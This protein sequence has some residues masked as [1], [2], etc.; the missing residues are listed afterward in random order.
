[1]YFTEVHERQSNYFGEIMAIILSP[2][3]EGGVAGAP[4]NQCIAKQIPAGV[5][6]CLL[7][8]LPSR[9]LDFKMFHNAASSEVDLFLR[10][11]L[12]T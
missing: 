2:P 10:N 9:F 5:V 6:D 1:M 3:F 4:Y 12:K 11:D 8:F 7:N